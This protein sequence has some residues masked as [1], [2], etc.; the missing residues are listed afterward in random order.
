MIYNKK[1]FYQGPVRFENNERLGL[2]EVLQWRNGSY[3]IAG[4]YDG[5]EAILTLN[6]ALKG[7]NKFVIV[8]EFTIL[9]KMNDCNT[10]KVCQNFNQKINNKILSF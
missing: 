10:L 4:I 3:M 2:V 6:P 1:L 5:T 8:E 7:I 9:L